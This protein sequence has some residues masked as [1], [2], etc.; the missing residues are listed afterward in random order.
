MSVWFNDAEKA[1][2]LAIL[3][4]RY[5][6]GAG[7]RDDVLRAKMALENTEAQMR[8]AAASERNATYMLWSVIAATVS[9]FASLAS[10]LI[11]V[12]AHR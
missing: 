2:L 5:K 9:A 12:F 1:D 10:V 7:Q 8:A 6:S 3:D 11:L 4:N